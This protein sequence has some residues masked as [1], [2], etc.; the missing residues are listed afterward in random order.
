MHPPLTILYLD[1]PIPK[2]ASFGF[3]ARNS[4]PAIAP[5]AAIPIDL[6]SE[7]PARYIPRPADTAVRAYEATIA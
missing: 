2:A 4:G 3:S 1:A 7:C 5:R 6:A